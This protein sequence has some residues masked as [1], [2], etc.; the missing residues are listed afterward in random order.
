[1]KTLSRILVLLVIVGTAMLES[2]EDGASIC[3]RCTCMIANKTSTV[4]SY[5]LLDC[6]RKNLQHMINNWPEMFNTIDPEREIVLS[7][8]GN[9]IINL[10][11]L[12]TTIT[13]L[14]FSCC[15]CNLETLSSGLFKD[16]V[17][18]LR[19]DLS[20]N[21]LSGDALSRDV[22]RG[23][24]NAEYNSALLLLDELDLSSNVIMQLQEDAFVHIAMLRHLSLARNPL[25]Q[26]TDST[27][28]ALAQL[29]NLEHLDLSYCSLTDID[30][31]AFDGMQALRELH[32]QGNLFTAI[33]QAV[34]QLFS[35][36]F[37]HLAENPIE[38]LNIAQPLKQLVQL[39]VSSM[40][41]LHTVEVESFENVKQLKI[42]TGSNNPALEVFDLKILRHLSFLKELVLSRS[43][44][45]HL[46]TPLEDDSAEQPDESA[47]KNALEVL[48]LSENP[49]HCDCALQRV[50][51]YVQFSQLPHYVEDDETRCETPYVLTSL[52]LSELIDIEV[53]DQL[54]YD[55]PNSPVY[56][57]PAFLR[58]RSIFLTLLSVG[59]VVGLGIIIGLVIVCLKRRLK[60][61]MMA[62]SSPVRYTSVRESKSMPIYQ[63]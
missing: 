47:Y 45:K 3:E 10:Q 55:P 56:E 57:K 34:Y 50:L 2:Y 44:L 33:P 41:V 7:L 26:I 15:H 8:S 62:V 12:P 31:T 30:A 27:A 38:V 17:N 11:Q 29:I 48:L 37:L 63:I 46:H 32:I 54:V 28:T 58:P 16:T 59:I 18:V 6:T 53:C 61:Q 4:L 1:M 14:V 24:Y 39:N 35:L 9:N 51:K 20:F 13:T 21:K 42:Y 22:F 52:H 25:G 60:T 43:N 36:H 40:P 5:D 23:Q 49:W 19:V